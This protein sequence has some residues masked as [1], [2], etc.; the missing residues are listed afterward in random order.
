MQIDYTSRSVDFPFTNHHW[1]E[2]H[3]WKDY[4]TVKNEASRLKYMK[5][6]RI[7]GFTMERDELLWVD[8]LLHIAINLKEM[9]VDD[10]WRVARIPF[11]QLKYLK[12]KHFLIPCQD[13]DSYFVLITSPE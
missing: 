10:F 9:I 5:K 1:H 2:P 4:A 7:V 13:I 11:S 6:I 12:L 8:L 3:L